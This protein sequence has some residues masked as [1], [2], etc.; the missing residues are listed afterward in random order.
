MSTDHLF[1]RLELTSYVTGDIT[2]EKKEQIEA[3]LKTCAECSDFVNELQA[4]RA[5]FL[6][7][8]PF[9]DALIDETSTETDVKNDSKKTTFFTF[10]QMISVAA[11]LLVAFLVAFQFKSIQQDVIRE[12]G[13]QLKGGE[14]IHLYVQAVNG[15]VEQRKNNTYYP[16]ERIQVCYSSPWKNY[17]M[18]F[19][20]DTNGVVS[21]FYPNV[22][23]SSIY[24]ENGT[25][26]P[27]PNSIRLDSYVGPECYFLILS[28]QPESA[29][30]Y[31][32]KIEK[33]I[34]EQPVDNWYLPTTKGVTVISTVI[35]K[36]SVDEM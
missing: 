10:P 31:Q 8:F 23:D 12:P 36:R 35:N 28:E 26:V 22:G 9:D 19:S 5:S 18:L 21:R 27:L 20:A 13:F 17:L 32:R 7:S 33:A 34:K 25:G 15:G 16:N 24:I 30:E 1:D 11:L 14:E 29:D 3:H 2:G 4:D 6:A